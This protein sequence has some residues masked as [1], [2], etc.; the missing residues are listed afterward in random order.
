MSSNFEEA[1]TEAF[2]NAIR[3][4]L[5]GRP[6]RLLAWEEVQDKLDL[7]D[8]VYRG[9]Q[10]VP[11]A[12][13]IGSVERYQDFDRAFLPKRD[14]L[15]GRWD[16]ISSA[17]YRGTSPPPIELYKVGDAYFVID[18]HHR[19]SVAKR[20]GVKFIDAEVT[21]VESAVPLTPEIDAS[22]LKI[23]GERARF[24]KRT[25][26]DE[27]CPEYEI[28]PTV[29][30]SYRRLL[31]HI[32]TYHYHVK[33]ETGKEIPED[34][35]V[36][37]WCNELYIPLVEIIRQ[38]GVLDHF[39]NRTETDLYLWI[40]DHQHHL[41]ELCGPGVSH[42]AAA[43]HFTSHRSGR[44]LERAVQTIQGLFDDP[45]CELIVEEDEN[46]EGAE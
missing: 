36:R 33:L 12:K 43:Q 44:P 27:I 11:I 30:G 41:Q 46:K 26:L 14:K 3:S 17:F 16:S 29:A 21:E 8:Q 5:T 31:E 35:A 38:N 40:I 32:V 9:V 24:L 34:K 2:W 7:R 19:V 15:K 42:T 45:V 28:K 10:S 13:I 18:G 22:D 20:M 39:P 37:A 1:R 6:N 25:H 4:F 23:L